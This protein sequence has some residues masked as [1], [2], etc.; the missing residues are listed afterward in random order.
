MKN[1]LLAGGTAGV[2]L[3]MVACGLGETSGSEGSNP[4]ADLAREVIGQDDKAEQKAKQKKTIADIRNAGT[5]LF[6]WLT[7]EIGAGAAG[8]KQALAIADY[9]RITTAELEKILVPQYI[10]ALP[11]TDGWGHPYEYFLV[12]DDLLAQR[13]M[14]IRSPGRDGQF[15][16]EPYSEG[17]FAPELFDED[18]VWADGF[19]V[20][21]PQAPPTNP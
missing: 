11:T 4:L 6:S 3:V 14:L 19:F 21:W 9:P 7:D 15:A 10:A 8:Q 12:T 18:I 20:R 13:V 2:L 1:L 17:S 16:P 5:A